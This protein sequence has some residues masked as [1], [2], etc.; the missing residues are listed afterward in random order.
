MIMIDQFTYKIYLPSTKQYS[1]FS[2]LSN[3]KY[4]DI[5]KYIQN[6]DDYLVQYFDWVLE[7]LHVDG[8]GLNVMDRVDK[9]CVL[10]NLRILCISDQMELVYTITSGEDTKKQTVKVNLY[11]VLDAVVNH[12]VD[13]TK[14]YDVDKDCSIRVQLDD[15]LLPDKHKQ[16]SEMI[17]GLRLYGNEY[18]LSNIS[19]EHAEILDKLPNKIITNIMK[20][21][22][23]LNTKYNIDAVKLNHVPGFEQVDNVKLQLFDDSFY[24]YLKLTYNTNLKDL[25]YTQYILTKHMG[26]N[27]RDLEDKTPQDTT[28]YVTMF[29]KEI[30]DKKKAQEKQN[31]PAGS[32]SLPGQSFVQ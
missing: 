26:F 14:W 18:N 20:Y 2:L 6:N 8:P 15:N 13:Y 23:D 29:R 11:D 31:K 5:V 4:I 1:R 22:N 7:D 3:R 28:T 17:T 30:D 9:F 27:M 25:Y 24:E 19:N 12:E 32:I 21:I 10:L 16:W